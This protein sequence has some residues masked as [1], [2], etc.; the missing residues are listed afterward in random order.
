MGR[1]SAQ[2]APAQIR[3]P[4]VHVTYDAY[5]KNGRVKK[6]LP[7]VI[8]VMSDLAGSSTSDAAKAKL[9]DR[10]FEEVQIDGDKGINRFMAKLA[11]RA[12][13]RVPNRLT[14]EGELSVE[15]TFRNVDDFKPARIASQIPALN[16]L[17]NRRQQLAALLTKMDGNDALVDVVSE[18]VKALPK[19]SSMDLPAVAAVKEEQ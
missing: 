4:R 9:A 18:L 17:L 19:P 1:Q 11:P 2:D 6:E 8:G 10:R 13:L 3:P 14:H 5:T 15:L 7:F 16:Q 12:A